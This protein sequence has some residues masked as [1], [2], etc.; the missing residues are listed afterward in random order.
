VLGT[1]HHAALCAA[2]GPG[3]TV[4]VIGDGAV[5]LCAVAASRRLGAEDVILVSTHPERGEVGLELGASEIVSARG[6]RAAH[7]I[8]TMTD[9]LG[10]DS[11]LECVGTEASVRLAL[12]SARGGG[13]V[14][15]VGLP[16][17]VGEVPVAEIF[18]RGIGVK[19]GIAPVASYLP[20]LM[21]DVLDGRIDV[22]AIFDLTLDLENIA[23]GYRAMDD[24]RAVKALLKH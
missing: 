24:R 13:D 6:A 10:A 20:E 12:D 11:V 17:G 8:R 21:A 9:G 14:A 16:H 3:R 1:G 4:V 18:R 23:S 19:G 7:E 22:A 15:M 2:V 5:G